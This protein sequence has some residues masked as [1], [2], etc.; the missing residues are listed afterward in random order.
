MLC[1][2]RAI[3]AAEGDRIKGGAHRPGQSSDCAH[4]SRLPR[5]IVQ[6]PKN[7]PSG[8]PYLGHFLN[9]AP[10]SLGGEPARDG[11][12]VVDHELGDLPAGVDLAQ[13]PEVQMCDISRLLL[14]RR[15]FG[16]R[17]NL[18]IL[19]LRGR[20]VGVGIVATATADGN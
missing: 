13:V 16:L 15:G 8:A 20:T 12:A 6:N 18:V 10:V 14:C 11:G 19:K 4:F 17:G 7:K 3:A 2:Q 5:A 9:H 1:V